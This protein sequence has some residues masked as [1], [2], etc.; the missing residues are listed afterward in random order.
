MESV[1]QEEDAQPCNPNP[2]QNITAITAQKV[3][4]TGLKAFMILVTF[5]LN[6]KETAP[7]LHHAE[8]D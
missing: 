4:P 3:A 8:L 7:H 6:P 1:V 5:V 2:P